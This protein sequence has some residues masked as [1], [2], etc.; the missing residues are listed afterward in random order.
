M[1]QAYIDN[2]LYSCWPF[3]VLE[4]TPLATPIEIEKAARDIT[5]KIG[6]GVLDA[7]KYMTPA[8]RQKRDE[9]LIREAK[10]ALQDSKKRLLAE[11]WYVDPALD[12]FKNTKAQSLSIND[13]LLALGI[14]LRR[15]K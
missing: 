10:S 3:W 7:Q 12:E 15:G 13:W 5:A 1:I 8:G 14:N 2:P 4:L 9:F 11:F 6:L